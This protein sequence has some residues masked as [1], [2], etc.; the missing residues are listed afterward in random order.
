MKLVRK[1]VVAEPEAAPERVEPVAEKPADIAPVLADL[2]RSQERMT[3][4]IEKVAARPEASAPAVKRPP[5]YTITVTERDAKGRA[6]KY[7]IEAKN[8]TN[9]EP[10]EFQA[11]FHKGKD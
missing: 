7:D 11:G 3:A 6:V 8:P 4:A 2:V 1:A 5:A 9:E 10:D